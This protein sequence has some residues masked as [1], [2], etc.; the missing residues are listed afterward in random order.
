MLDNLVGTALSISG[1]STF[2]GNVSVGSG[3]TMYASTGIV[4][5]TAFYGSGVNLTDLILGRIEGIQVQEEGVNVGSGLSFATL[6]FVGPGVTATGVGTTA[7]ITIPGFAQDA[8][9]NL[10][11][12][13][14]A[15]GSY[16]PSTGSACFNTFLG[17]NAGNSITTG[18]YNF[19]VGQC[20]GYYNTTGSRNIF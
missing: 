16:D 1:I 15:G 9:G 8:D 7:T 2:G 6:N 13:T 11:A 14:G 18:D 5:A 4:S 19:F 10:F 3:I 17:C 12:G 20:A